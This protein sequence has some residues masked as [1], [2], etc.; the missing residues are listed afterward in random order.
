MHWYVTIAP[1][2]RVFDVLLQT[3]D[4]HKEVS[5]LW[6]IFW[7]CAVLFLGGMAYGLH[8]KPGSPLSLM[9]CLLT[10]SLSALL[11][12]APAGK[13]N[14]GLLFPLLIAAVCF[15]SLGNFCGNSAR[16]AFYK[17]RARKH[18]SSS[19]TLT[20]CPQCGSIKCQSKA[21]DGAWTMYNCPD[22]SLSETLY[23]G[24]SKI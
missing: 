6:H 15:F 7:A 20:T 12:S 14:F 8:N 22:C 13:T 11:F 21:M 10:G 4:M 19:W 1:S 5:M 3:L 17:M 9:I 2:K 23:V 16:K 18:R 24:L